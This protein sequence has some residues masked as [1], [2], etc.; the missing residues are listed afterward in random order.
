LIRTRGD[1]RAPNLPVVDPAD[2][3]S[4]LWNNG[5]VVTVGT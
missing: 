1:V 5:G 2:G 3:L 4:K